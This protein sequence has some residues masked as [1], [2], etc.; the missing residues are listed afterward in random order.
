MPPA[1]AGSPQRACT[2][3]RARLGEW[4]CM[5]VCI[6]GYVTVSGCAYVGVCECVP[7]CAC[8]GV[9]AGVHAWVCVYMCVHL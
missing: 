9:S 5:C 2:Q 8:V 3:G 7:V 4:V 6:R 1:P